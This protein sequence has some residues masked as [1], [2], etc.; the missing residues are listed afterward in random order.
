MAKKIITL[1]EIHPFEG[2]SDWI[3]HYA[4]DQN[5][6]RYYVL[7]VETGVE[8]DEAVDLYPCRYTYKAT[9]KPL[10]IQKPEEQGEEENAT[11]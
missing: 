5:G 1:K 2:H 10:E 9:K 4:E 7:Q 11:N 8:Y 3:C 6:K